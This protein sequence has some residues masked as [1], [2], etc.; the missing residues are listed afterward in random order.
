[1][2][3]SR[4]SSKKRKLRR[5]INPKD[6][7]IYKALKN[8]DQATSIIDQNGIKRWLKPYDFISALHISIKKH[9]EHLPAVKADELIF[10]Y[11]M[12]AIQRCLQMV[13]MLNNSKDFDESDLHDYIVRKFEHI[14][15]EMLNKDY[16]TEQ[17]REFKNAYEKSMSKE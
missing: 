9:K 14:T 17:A 1:M 16:Q 12:P 10:N 8:P 13:L 6:N 5:K 7:A 3:K 2:S 11:E 15:L 4:S